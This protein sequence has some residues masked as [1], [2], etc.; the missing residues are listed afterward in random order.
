MKAILVKYFGPTNTRGSRLKASD[1][2]GNSVTIPYPRTLSSGAGEA[3]AARLLCAKMQWDSTNLVE[4]ELKEGTV[5]VFDC[6]G[7]K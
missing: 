4:G 6:R 1:L 5:F 7:G 2:D 3:H